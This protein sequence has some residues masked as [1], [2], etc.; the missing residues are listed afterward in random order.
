MRPDLSERLH[1]FLASEPPLPAFDARTLAFCRARLAEYATALPGKLAAEIGARAHR[2]LGRVLIVVAEHDVMGTLA[3]V[4]AAHATGNRVRVKARATRSLL[5]ALTT[6]LAI[7]DC[8]ILDWDSRAQDDAEV[9]DGIDGVLLAGGDELIRH[10]RRVTPSGVRL[11]ELGPKL[12]CAAIG[13]GAGDLDRLADALV[14]DVTLFGQGVCSSPQWILADDEAIVPHLRTRLA[15]CAVLPAETRLL[16][17]ARSEALRL[18]ARLGEAIAV[19]LDATSGWGVTVSRSLDDRLPRGFAIV[20]GV[21]DQLT[22]L[23]RRHRHELQTLGIAGHVPE[24][25]GFTHVCPIGRMHQ[26]SPLAP[27][28]GFF[29]LASLVTFTSREEPA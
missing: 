13:S 17:H 11:I 24:A 2:P 1:R 14:A 21:A 26:R 22:E 12:S 16:Q 7:D 20:L 8:E 10:Y 15:H 25:A 9:L 28:D 27:H 19:D 18:R 29:E 5:V 3:A 6:A 23:A 4:V